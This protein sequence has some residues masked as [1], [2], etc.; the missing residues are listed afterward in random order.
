MSWVATAVIGGSVIGAGASI[1]GAN[2]NADAIEGGANTA[3]GFQ[4]R[5]L[6]TQLALLR[7]QAEVGNSAL[8]VLADLFGLDAPSAIDFDNLGGGTN[9]RFSG[10]EGFQEATQGLSAIGGAT[11]RGRPVFTDGNGGIFT[12]R[13]RNATVGNSGVEFLGQAGEGGAGLRFDGTRVKS[14]SGVLDFRGG[15]FFDGRGKRANPINVETPTPVAQ[16]EQ[17]APG[18]APSTGGLNLEDLVSNNPL[19]KFQQEQ[20]FKAATRA[21]AAAGVNQSGNFIDEIGAQAG[22]RTA[23]GIQ[24]FVLNPLFQLAGFGAQGSADAAN[25]VGTNANN[26]SN[27]ATNSANARGSAFQNAGNTVG[28]LLSDFGQSRLVGQNALNNPNQRIPG[29]TTFNQ[30]GSP[31]FQQNTDPFRV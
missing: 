26:L 3:A 21:G 19:I 31:F 1:F 6:D 20:D 8:G 15:E 9:Q 5:A 14:A 18:G 25:A 17:A 23:T 4:N 28:N 13:G 29:G 22:R 12:S 16:P 7:P 2:R 30:P 10:A 24:D 11:W 27:L